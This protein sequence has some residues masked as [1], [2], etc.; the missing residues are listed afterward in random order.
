MGREV[1]PDDVRRLVPVERARLTVESHAAEVIQTVSQIGILL[2]LEHY[3][4]WPERVN[5]T[6][7]QIDCFLR[8]GMKIVEQFLGFSVLRRLSQF[9]WR[10]TR[11]GSEQVARSASGAHHVPHLALAQIAGLV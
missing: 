4:S 1:Q 6:R 2:D 9:V 10:D 8:F 3:Q 11:F 5:G 7:R